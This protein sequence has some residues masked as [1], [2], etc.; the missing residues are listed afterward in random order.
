M[1]READV[2]GSALREGTSGS[3]LR[4]A[5]LAECWLDASANQR[6]PL[7]EMG[8]RAVIRCRRVPLLLRRE[9]QEAERLH[10]VDGHL[11]PGVGVVRTRD[12]GAATAL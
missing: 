1:V 12:P 10:Q 6:V 4:G 9:E 11:A 2:S 7:D 8:G 5:E 3:P